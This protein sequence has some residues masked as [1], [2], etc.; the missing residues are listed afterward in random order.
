MELP[1]CPDCRDSALTPGSDLVLLHS[2]L[3]HPADLSSLTTAIQAYLSS[4]KNLTLL[5]IDNRPDVKMELKDEESEEEEYLVAEVD[6]FGEDFENSD[7][8]Y[9]DQRMALH[10]TQ[11]LDQP[12]LENPNKH[13]VTEDL[14]LLII[15]ENTDR[16]IK[17]TFSQRM[18]TQMVVDN[19]VLKKKKGPFLTTSGRIINWRCHVASC[20]YTAVTKEGRLAGFEQ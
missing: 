16:E 1:R 18:N 7:E 4:H 6:P 17:F 2:H 11:K 10:V 8:E 5:L 13:L 20:M 12:Q 15:Q 19:F 9:V 3:T 14:Q